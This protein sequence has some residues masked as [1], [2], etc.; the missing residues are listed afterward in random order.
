MKNIILLSF[1]VLIG[2]NSISC[3]QNNAREN[4]TNVKIKE[5]GSGKIQAEEQP[6]CIKIDTLPKSDYYQANIDTF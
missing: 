1:S 2:M 3:K 4:S 6:F 5:A